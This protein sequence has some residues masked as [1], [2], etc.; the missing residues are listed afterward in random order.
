MI[1]H[2]KYCG[3]LIDFKQTK[4]GKLVPVEIQETA[5][6][7]GGG[8]VIKGY[9]VHFYNCKGLKKEKEYN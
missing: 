5:F 9:Q 8:N 7:A 1:R 6:I 4:R 3:A 2:C